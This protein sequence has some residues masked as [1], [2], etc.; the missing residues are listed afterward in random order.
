MRSSLLD[1]E[2][3]GELATLEL[4]ARRIVDGA[5]AGIHRSPHPGSS[6]EFVE[7]KEYAPGDEVKNI[8]WKAYGKFDKYYVKRY[9]EE[10]D[11]TAYLVVDQSGSMSY[12]A[13]TSKW[14]YASMLA[15]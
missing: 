2:A 4:R 6:V 1:P 3:L 5:L 10:T 7:H 15:A 8:D 13:P 11:L 14:T 9:E 12:G